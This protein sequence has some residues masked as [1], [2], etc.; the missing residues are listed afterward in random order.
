MIRFFGLAGS[1]QQGAVNLALLGGKGLNLCELTCAGFPVPP[2]FVVTTVAYRR[3]VE[4]NELAKEIEKLLG[5]INLRD[6]ISLERVSAEIRSLFRAGRIPTDVAGPIRQAY[7]ELRQA[8]GADRVAVRSSATAE[9][10]PEA[11]FAGQQDTYL[12]VR[13]QEKVLHA[14]R[15]CWGSLW[16]ARAIGYRAQ[17]G[18]PNEGLALAVVVQKMVM[19]EAAGVMFTANPVTGARTEVVINAAWGLGE[20]IVGGKVTPDRIVVEK[21]TGAVKELQISEK[22]VMTTAETD[23]TTERELPED[24]RHARVLD[25]AQ[26][27]TLARLGHRIESHYRAPQDIEWCLCSGSFYVVQARPITALPED[28]EAVERYRHAEIERLR[29]LAAGKRR[30]WVK[31]NLNEV[32]PLPTPLTW[33]IVRKFMSGDGGFGRMYQLLGYRPSQEVRK[34]GFLELIGGRIYSDPERAAQLFWE[35]MPLSYNLDEVAKNPKLMDSAPT[36]FNPEK[37]DGR[38]LLSLPRFVRDFRRCSRRTKELSAIVVERFRTEVVPK[39]MEWLAR[40]QQQDLS[41]L[42]VADLLKELDERIERGFNEIGCES[43]LPGFFGGMAQAQ[44][45]GFLVQLMGE[46]K[47]RELTLVLTQGLEGD[48]T[49]EQNEALFALAQGLMT[50]EEF[51]QRYGHRAVGEMELSH[52]RWR[53]DDS[54]LRQV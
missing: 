14:V 38:F 7:E 30:V 47:G 8:V 22:R 34:Q 40:K 19:A 48:S 32:L 54:Y 4:E 21:A 2:G 5:K 45:E 36:R 51:L 11:S 9:D 6:P 29:K 53:E 41:S 43:L 39:F 10:L 49:V 13:G 28:P 52:P 3:F 33:D 46:E 37:A 12:N 23:G 24:R 50:R 27:A 18:I 44:L 16:T 1:A 42:S 31:H 17:Q 35:G 15:S 25:D 26:V 20:A